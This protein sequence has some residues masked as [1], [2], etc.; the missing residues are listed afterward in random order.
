MDKLPLF[1]HRYRLTVKNIPNIVESYY[2]DVIYGVKNLYRYFRVIWH[3]RDYDWES[4]AYLIEFK[5][6]DMI[7]LF[8]THGYHLDTDK[9]V[10]QMKVCA[11]ILRR[12]QT[13][14]YEYTCDKQ[15]VNDQKYLGLLLGKYL[16][17]WWE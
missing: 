13:N 10:K 14:N 16:R 11:E 9:S 12:L 7:E 3:Q 17:H 2:Y 8:E 1:H 6:R 15:A 4:L 5:L